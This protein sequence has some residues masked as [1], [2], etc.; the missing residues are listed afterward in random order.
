MSNK[1]PLLSTN[2]FKTVKGEKLGYRTYILYM[3]AFKQNSKGIN[4]CSHASAG[5]AASCLV[6]SGMGG[7]Y[8]TVQKGRINR[9]EF[10]LNDRLGFLFQLKGEIES[11]IRL[12]KDK[13][14]PVIRLNG[15]YLKVAKISLSCF[16][17]FNSTTIPRIGYVLT[18][19][20]LAITI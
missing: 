12:N 11:A 19:Y 16:L 2:N 20:Y 8:T 10:F 7:M 1:R 6:G 17:T 5:C 4:V 3:S 13:A 18:R 14:I 9:T 15:T